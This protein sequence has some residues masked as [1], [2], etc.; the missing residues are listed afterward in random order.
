[1][2][3]FYDNLLSIR[4]SHSF[5]HDISETPGALF[6][7]FGTNTQSTFKVNWLEFGGQSSLWPH[8]THSLNIKYGDN[9]NS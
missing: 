2:F 1:M 9:D 8:E 5:E 3:C 4:P 6:F 7:I